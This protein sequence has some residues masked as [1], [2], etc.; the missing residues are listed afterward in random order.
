MRFD[1]L[2]MKPLLHSG[3]T[4]RTDSPLARRLRLAVFIEHDIVYRHFVQSHVFADLIAAHDVTF[5]FPEKGVTNKRLTVAVDAAELGASIEWV[6]VESDRIEVWRRLF[7]VSQLRWR[8][9]SDWQQLRAVTRYVVGK[10]AAK[11]Y[12]VLAFPGIYQLFKKWSLRRIAGMPT[13]LDGLL[14]RLQPDALVHPTVL[15]GLFIND[16]V[17]LARARNIPSILIMNSWDNPATKRAVVG[18][19]DHLLV[20]GPQTRDLAIRFMGIELGC[21]SCFGCAQFDIYRQ[22]PRISRADFCAAHGIDPS[23]RILLYAGS[24]KGSDEFAHLQAIDAAI[25]NG[26]LNN[27]VVVYRPHPWGRGGHKG[28]RL[29]DHPW[30]HVRFESSMRGYL[31][32][33]R[34]GRKR[35]FLA[36]YADTHDVLSSIDALVSPLSTILLEGVLHGKPVLCFLPDEKVGSSLHLQARHAHF[37]GMYQNPIFLKARGDAALIGK[38]EELMALVGDRGYAGSLQQTKDFFVAPHPEPYGPRL[39]RFVEEA[40]EAWAVSSRAS[41]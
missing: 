2:P 24:S 14:D 37:D 15:E 34:A 39:R 6:P 25:E 27:V 5:I 26:R 4:E 8:P 19:P 36:D 3:L 30:R 40:V 7:Q 18:N 22:V 20:W 21:V 9:G 28:E 32:D 35:I 33:V 31:E 38:L 29:L 11:L 10:R 12:T 17:A 23:K 1:A 16:V 41:T 13:V